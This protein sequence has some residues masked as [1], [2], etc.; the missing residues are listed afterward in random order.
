MMYHAVQW[1]LE[2][3]VDTPLKLQIVLHFYEHAWRCG[4]ATQIAGRIY[5][6]IWST[7]EALRELTED[8]ILHATGCMEDPVYEYR[9][10]PEYAE[11]IALLIQCYNEPIERDHLQQQ[12]RRLA[13]E[14]P[15]R[16]AARGGFAFEVQ[17]F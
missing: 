1:L 8:G 5:R 7:R 2:R 17:P 11:P 10:I 14:A 9:P 6:D 16:R 4:T 3:A 12:V 13:G 15:Y